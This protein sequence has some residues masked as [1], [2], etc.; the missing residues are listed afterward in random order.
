MGDQVVNM[1]S[2]YG[3]NYSR[4]PSILQIFLAID[5]RG[6]N[7]PDNRMRRHYK[8]RM[9]GFR[10]LEQLALRLNKN[11]AVLGKPKPVNATCVR[12]VAQ[13]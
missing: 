2:W 11:I 1:V 4:P 6:N 9:I 10:V 13:N 5:I 7:L 3:Y 8:L 12:S